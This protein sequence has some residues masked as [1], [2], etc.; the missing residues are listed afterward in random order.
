MKIL[1]SF[2]TVQD[3]YNILSWEY[4]DE[5]YHDPSYDRLLDAGFCF[6]DWDIGFASKEPF[7]HI[8]H[9]EGHVDWEET[10]SDVGWL[11]NEMEL[12][13]CGYRHIEYG[14]YHWYLVYHS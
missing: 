2:D 13:C 11:V 14:G 1:I 5:Y 7:T 4:P 12:N 9:E 10:D 6:D 8:E 3:V